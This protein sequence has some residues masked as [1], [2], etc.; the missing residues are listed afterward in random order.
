[1][2]EIA[3]LTGVSRATVS[4]V[5]SGKPGI[6]EKTRRRIWTVVEIL[7]YRPSRPI[8]PLVPEIPEADGCLAQENSKEGTLGFV[9]EAISGKRE[10]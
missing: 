9:E 1:M 10:A 2:A 3:D 5:I 6:P 8:Q 4:R 7:H